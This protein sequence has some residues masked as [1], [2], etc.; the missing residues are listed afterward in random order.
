MSTYGIYSIQATALPFPR[1]KEELNQFDKTFPSTYCVPGDVL[2]TGDIDPEQIPPIELVDRSE[3][4]GQGVS[5]EQAE[6]C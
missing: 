5:M 3:T 6:Q 4:D 1:P 2:G